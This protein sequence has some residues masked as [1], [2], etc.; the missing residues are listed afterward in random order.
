MY[1]FLMNQNVPFH[2]IIIWKLKLP[3]KIKIFFWYLQRGVILT[4]DNLAKR[5]W[6]GSQK[7]C[8]CNSNETIQHLFFD[9][10][11]AKVIWRVVQVATGISQP[12][13]LAHMAGDWLSWAKPSEKK[14]ILAGSAALIWA[15]WHCRND[16][17]FNNVKYNSFL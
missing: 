13:S 9:C 8:Y 1:L 12:R 6:I 14:I 15:I 10:P 4:K 5:N 2:N 17:Y 11:H 7:C 3:L 16:I